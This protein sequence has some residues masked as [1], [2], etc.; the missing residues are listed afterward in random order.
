[1][2][3]PYLSYFLSFHESGDFFKAYALMGEDG[4]CTDYHSV[5]SSPAGYKS[6]T[7]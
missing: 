3:F 6:F 2:P 4:L 7:L 1:M 5:S